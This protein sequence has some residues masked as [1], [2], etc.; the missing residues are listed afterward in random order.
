MTDPLR[1]FADIIRS[2]WRARTQTNGKPA[3]A[4]T[5]T[6]SG[7]RASMEAARGRRTAP[8]LQSQ[9][10]TR[11]AACNG[12]SR[13][14]LRETFVETVLLWELGEELAPDPAFGE[15]VMQVSEQLASDPA[16]CARLDQMLDRLSSAP[17]G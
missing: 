8:S 3:V 10:K 6:A 4:S 11:V 17:T 12:A 1:P 13:S 15:M 9:L 5:A 2:L 16:I 14:R 7:V